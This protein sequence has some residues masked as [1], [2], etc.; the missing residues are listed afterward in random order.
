MSNTL[1]KSNL[2][3]IWNLNKMNEF[4]PPERF[5]FLKKQLQFMSLDLK[6][7]RKTG[8]FCSAIKKS[9]RRQK[10]K[11]DALKVRNSQF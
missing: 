11:M 1:I 7:A 8:E 5:D 2:P 6:S 3:F 9:G 4:E 10:M